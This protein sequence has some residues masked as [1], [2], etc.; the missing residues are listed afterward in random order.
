MTV[1]QD[2]AKM[3]LLCQ[4]SA[5]SAPSLSLSLSLSLSPLLVC[6]SIKQTGRRQENVLR[7]DVLCRFTPQKY[8]L[9]AK[10]GAGLGQERGG[11]DL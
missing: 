11:G 2:F 1:A 3:R 5:H 9:R 4:A 6:R 10:N 7:L 8:T